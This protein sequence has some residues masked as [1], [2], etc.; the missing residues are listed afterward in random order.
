VLFQSP[1]IPKTSLSPEI[2]NSGIYFILFSF[3]DGTSFY[4]K[5]SFDSNLCP[6]KEGY[7][8]DLE[9]KI[10]MRKSLFEDSSFYIYSKEPEDFREQSQ[11]WKALMKGA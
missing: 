10:F 7:L 4:I 11:F 1:E 6:F 2:L 9:T 5:T 3:A 8:F